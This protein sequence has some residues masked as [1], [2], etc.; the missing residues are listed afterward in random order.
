[1]SEGNDNN[2]KR[3]DNDMG[4]NALQYRK[5]DFNKIN[6][7]IVGNIS[8]E[9]ALKDINPIQWSEEVLSG[10]KKVIITKENKSE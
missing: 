7:R 2:D 6:S 3:E 1:M 4:A 9:E 10:R 5:L 8:S